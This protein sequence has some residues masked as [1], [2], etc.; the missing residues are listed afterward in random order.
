M[1]RHRALFPADGGP[2]LPIIPGTPV[3]PETPVEPEVPTAPFVP[4][5]TNLSSRGIVGK[6]ENRMIAGFVIDGGQAIQV[7]I[8]GVGPTLANFGV[9][10]AVGTPF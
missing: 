9:T 3:D 4:P 8:C 5:L 10:A 6:N 1:L 7:L 2:T